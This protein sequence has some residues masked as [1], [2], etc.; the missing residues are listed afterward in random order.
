M[1]QHGCPQEEIH[2]CFLLISGVWLQHCEENQDGCSAL[3]VY[4]LAMRKVVA[5]LDQHD[6]SR[7][8]AAGMTELQLQV[9]TDKEPKTGQITQ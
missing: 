5:L 6:A 8:E 4:L 9:E 7:P 1:V 3:I 2:L